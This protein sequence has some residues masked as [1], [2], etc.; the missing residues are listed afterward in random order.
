ME[1]AEIHR[2]LTAGGARGA[3][4]AFDAHVVASILAVGVTEAQAAGAPL[5]EALGINGEELAA[6]VAELFPHAAAVFARV[7]SEALAPVSREEGALRSLLSGAA[8]EAGPLPLRLAAMLARRC[9]RADALWLELGL[10]NGRELTW[11]MER[12]FEALARRN[13]QDMDWKAF[14]SREA[15]GSMEAA[16]PQAPPRE[17]STHI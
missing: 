12:H 14:L 6:L 15:G 2:W 11:L 4:D 5:S 9:Q 8:T 10:R 16:A 3:C 13:A 17:A 7:A 1:A